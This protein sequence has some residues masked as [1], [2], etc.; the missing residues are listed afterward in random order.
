[1]LNIYMLLNDKLKYTPITKV[2]I[3]YSFNKGY[4]T[5]LSLANHVINQLMVFTKVNNEMIL[6]N[7]Y[8]K[9]MNK[10]TSFHGTNDEMLEYVK[11]KLEKV[12]F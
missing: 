4:L 2:S 1:M 5:E 10:L 9:E 8:D 6:M 7:L 11:E 3:L 12:G